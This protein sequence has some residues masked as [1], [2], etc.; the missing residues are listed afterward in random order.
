MHPRPTHV[1]L[2]RD[3]LGVHPRIPRPRNALPQ[4]HRVRCHGASGDRSTTAAV[5]RTTRKRSWVMTMVEHDPKPADW[6]VQTA[7]GSTVGRLLLQLARSERFPP[8]NILRRPAQVLENKTLGGDV[9]ITPEDEDWVPH[10]AAASQGKA[11]SRAI[12]SVA[13]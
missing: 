3:A 5:L 6:L 13:G 7:A 8:V 11:L 1:V 9:V 2:C 12:D 10:L 4:I